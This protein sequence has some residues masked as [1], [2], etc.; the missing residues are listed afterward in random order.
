MLYYYYIC[1]FIKCNIVH[2]LFSQKVKKLLP[3]PPLPPPP[4]LGLPPP[5]P[6]IG[7]GLIGG[8][9]SAVT[10]IVSTK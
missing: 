7:H 6:P 1:G 10:T 4:P 5:I 2:N 8:K 9:R 3:P